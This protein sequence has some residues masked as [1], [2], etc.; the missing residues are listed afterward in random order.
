M[1]MPSESTTNARQSD[2][3][4]DVAALAGILNVTEAELAATVGHE[5]DR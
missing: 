3:S 1:S 2:G 5:L 4:V